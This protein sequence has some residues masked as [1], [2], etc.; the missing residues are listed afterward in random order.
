MRIT[1]R[2]KLTAWY[3]L[4]FAAGGLIL[5][6]A[7]YLLVESGLVV[8]LSAAVVKVTDD[9]AGPAAQG[10][11]PPAIALAA[12]V[13]SDTVL[14]KLLVVSGI[15]LL[16]LAVI[17]VAVG[18][19]MSGRVLRP[20]RRISAT[21][22]QL[23]SETLHERIAMSG[24]RDE[25][26]ELAETFD[27]ML[28]RLEASFESQRRFVANAS[29]ELRTP[30]AIQRA[31]VQI[32]LEGAA[33]PVLVGQLLA[34]NRR[35]ERLI[36]G[37]L[38]LARSDRGLERREPVPLHEVVR[39]ELARFAA[40]ISVRNLRVVDDLQECWV[41]G[42][43]LLVGQLAGNLI[44]NAVQYNVD[45]GELRLGVSPD[46][47]FSVSNDGPEVD[48]GSVGELFEPFQRGAE[49]ITSDCGA[50]LGL[51]IVKSITAAHG[52]TVCAKARTGG[53][54]VVHVALPVVP[55]EAADRRD[56][57]VGRGQAIVDLGQLGADQ[58]QPVEHRVSR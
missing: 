42:D 4:L 55:A 46:G 22:Q 41:S 36:D 18:W 49:R 23:S 6:L 32:G 54:L 13:S 34:A 31:A 52:G 8:E 19:W 3:G 5:V 43:R 25:L 9:A 35:S 28:D 45:G 7:V 57:V 12:R 16:V 26:T 39:R 30:L 58:G 27:R 40:E 10:T 14:T 33:D 56:H 11:G 15:C 29:H 38:V 48:P 17:A 47:G 1:V 24:P 20:L 2:A 50:G 21:A 51:S 53:G 37:L 44:G